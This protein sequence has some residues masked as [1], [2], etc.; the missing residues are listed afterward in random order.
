MEDEV[1]IINDAFL[2]IEAAMALGND[3]RLDAGC[4]SGYVKSHQSSA[5]P[6][7]GSVTV[8]L[9]ADSCCLVRLLCVFDG[10]GSFHLMPRA[11]CAARSRWLRFWWFS[12]HC[13]PAKYPSAYRS[14]IPRY[15]VSHVVRIVRFRFRSRYDDSGCDR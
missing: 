6:R 9:W 2:M 1:N 4:S 13:R 8:A 7:D 11:S 5:K 10:G 14:S 3:L 15:T 12:H